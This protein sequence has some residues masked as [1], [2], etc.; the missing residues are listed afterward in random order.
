M[1]TDENDGERFEEQLKKERRRQR[2]RG[3]GKSHRKVLGGVGHEGEEKHMK[4]IDI[5]NKS[6]ESKEKRTFCCSSKY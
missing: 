3:R 6:Q 4:L 2:M 1:L 5:S